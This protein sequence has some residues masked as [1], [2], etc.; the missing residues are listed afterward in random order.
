[1]IA[2]ALHHGEERQYVAG[3]GRYRK[4]GVLAEARLWD[5]AEKAQA[6]RNYVAP[7]DTWAQNAN[8]RVV[9]VYSTIAEEEAPP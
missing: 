7:G 5:T 6:A 2:Y 1:M 4:T 8:W 9:P 3:P